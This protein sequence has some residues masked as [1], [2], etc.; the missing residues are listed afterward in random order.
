MRSFEESSNKI[1]A[2]DLE[3]IV[4]ETEALAERLCGGAVENYRIGPKESVA[5][6]RPAIRRAVP[7]VRKGLIRKGPGKG[8]LKRGNPNRRELETRRRTCHNEI[9]NRASKESLSQWMGRTSDKSIRRH[10][11]RVQSTR[12]E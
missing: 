10:N 9:W 2:K 5:D 4:E 6:R 7:A 1:E 12:V 8:S 11:G 3:E